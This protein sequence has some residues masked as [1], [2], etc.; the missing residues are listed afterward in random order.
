MRCLSCTS[1]ACAIPIATATPAS[2]FTAAIMSEVGVNIPGSDFSRPYPRASPALGHCDDVCPLGSMTMTPGQVDGLWV[3][4]WLERPIQA[5]KAPPTHWAS[6]GGCFS[7]G[8]GSSNFACHTFLPRLSSALFLSGTGTCDDF[9]I[10]GYAVGRDLLP[11]A[12]VDVQVLE[13][14]FEAVFVAFLL[15]S[16]WSLAFTQ[17]SIQ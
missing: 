1:S 2:A 12:S 5:R 7:G 9:A 6:V 4:R 14:S 10:P 3:R 13:G 16:D 15:P 17:F 11:I 8:G